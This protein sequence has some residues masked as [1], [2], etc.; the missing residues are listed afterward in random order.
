MAQTDDITIG[1]IPNDDP[2]KQLE[3]VVKQTNEQLRKIANEDRT[4]IKKDDAGDQ[5]LLM[6]YQKGGFSNGDLGIKLSQEGVDVLSATNDQL[7][8]SSDFNSFKIVQ[9]VEGTV[10][11]VQVSTTAAGTFLASE[12]NIVDFDNLPSRPAMIAYVEVGSQ[13]HLMPY[14]NNNVG[15]TDTFYNISVRLAWTTGLLGIITEVGG[16]TTFAG[17]INLTLNGGNPVKIYI[18]QETAA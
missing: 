16:I 8:W 5:R 4:L 10:P 9:V 7:I 6:G 15:G 13:G 11:S 12:M 2:Q 14:V 1:A 3:S 17:G 18:L